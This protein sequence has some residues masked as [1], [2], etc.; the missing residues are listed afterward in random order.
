MTSD[1]VTR[2][3]SLQHSK[4]YMQLQGMMPLQLVAAAVAW[5]NLWLF[6]PQTPGSGDPIVQVR[7]R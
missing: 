2:Q 7:L 3:V 1:A 5:Q 6:A 4:V